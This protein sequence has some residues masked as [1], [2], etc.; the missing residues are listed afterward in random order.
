MLGI[1]VPDA[2]MTAS[3]QQVNTFASK[4]KLTTEEIRTL[5]RNLWHAKILV[6][7]APEVYMPDENLREAV[8]AKINEQTALPS[9]QREVPEEFFIRVGGPKKPSEP[10]YAGEMRL[11]GSLK[12]EAAG[13]ESLIGLEYATNLRG[14]HLGNKHGS[15]WEFFWVGRTG[16]Y[17]VTKPETPNRISDLGPLENL[18]NL[19]VLDLECNAVSSL[20]SLSFLKNLQWLNLAENKITNISPLRHLTNLTFLSLRNDYYSPEWAGNNTIR[21]LSPLGNLSKLETLFV[22]LNPI[23]GRIDIVR[24]ASKTKK[25][26]R[27]MLRCIESS[28]VPRASTARTGGVDIVYL[29]HSPLT[30]ENVPDLDALLSARGVVG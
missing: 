19:K 2:L 12:A 28:L 27:R 25:S 5:L 20:L 16:K 9:S 1:F 10:I 17:R 3:V 8:V 22:D 6:L 18:K 13:I 29:V 24:S 14:L 4:Y 11:I 26:K 21:D 23:G 7:I 30:A 15:D